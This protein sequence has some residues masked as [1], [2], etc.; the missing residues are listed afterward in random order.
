MMLAFWSAIAD[1]CRWFCCA[2]RNM[3]SMVLRGLTP[4][5][6]PG[7]CSVKA[8]CAMSAIDGA[9]SLVCVVMAAAQCA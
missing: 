1:S 6:K 4:S 2:V 5:N 9:E 7:F 3:W 8:S